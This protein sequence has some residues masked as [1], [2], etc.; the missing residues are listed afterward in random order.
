MADLDL[1]IFMIDKQ[2]KSMH[3]LRIMPTESFLFSNFEYILRFTNMFPK[4]DWLSDMSKPFVF[5]HNIGNCI[6][7]QTRIFIGNILTSQGQD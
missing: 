5:N 2:N 3:M 6:S 7:F 4:T 1:F